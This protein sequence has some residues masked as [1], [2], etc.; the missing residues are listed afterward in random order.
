M[1]KR[2]CIF[3]ALLLPAITQADPKPNSFEYSIIFIGSFQDDEVS[4][5]LN[6]VVILDKYKVENIDS[7]KQGHLSLTQY[8]NEI[9]VYYNGTEITKSKIDI[10]FFLNAAITVNG[11][12]KRVK[13]DLRKGKV[14]LVD[15]VVEKSRNAQLR[16]LRIEQIQ[17][18]VIL[19]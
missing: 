17:E 3:I 11:K 13:L 9:R 12:L 2:Y 10:N 8:E 14:I 5:S 6:N 7:I 18:P 1:L 4:L 19:M 16:K 15:H